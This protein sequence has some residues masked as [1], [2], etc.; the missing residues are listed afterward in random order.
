VA[1]AS[2][3][4]AA[5]LVRFGRRGQAT[6]TLL[7][8]FGFGQISPRRVAS[9]GNERT[10]QT[11]PPVPNARGPPPAVLLFHTT[12]HLNWA[13]LFHAGWLVPHPPGASPS[14]HPTRTPLSPRSVLFADLLRIC[15]HTLLAK[16]QI[17]IHFSH[18]NFQ[19]TSAFFPSE[20][21]GGIS[22]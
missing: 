18:A 2:H 22:K 13:L 21:D 11:P 8:S 14:A 4:H 12:P 15:W 20:F 16:R 7:R 3:A 9:P 10:G 6:T 5:W 17:R 1:S 19:G